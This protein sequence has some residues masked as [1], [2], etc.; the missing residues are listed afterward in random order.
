MGTMASAP[1]GMG[2]PVAIRTASPAPTVVSGCWPTGA[3]P[4]TRSVTGSSIVAEAPS[5]ALAANPSIAQEGNPGLS[6]SAAPPGAGGPTVPPREGG[7]VG[8]RAV[9]P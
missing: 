8:G 6:G 2:A 9:G 3:R 5:D 4:T 1:A 7:F